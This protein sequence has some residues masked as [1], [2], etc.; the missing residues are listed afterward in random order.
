VAAGFTIDGQTRT[1]L[2][3]S[4]TLVQ[5]VVEIHAH[6]RPSNVS[7]VRAILYTTWKAHGV[8]AA[9][10]PI[11]SHIEACMAKYPVVSGSAVQH[12]TAGGL[13]TNYVEFVVTLPGTADDETPTQTATVQ[14]SVQNLHDLTNFDK[15][16]N[17]VIAALVAAA[18]A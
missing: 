11:A 7:F 9:L 10:A 2:V 17:P 15:Y 6:T 14:I 5:D 1:V 13:I 8:G 18:G 12:V 4:P 16:F 3:R